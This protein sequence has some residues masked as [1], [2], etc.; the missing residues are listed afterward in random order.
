MSKQSHLLDD[1]KQ[2]SLSLFGVSYKRLAVLIFGVLAFGVYVGFLLFGENSL[3][4]YLKIEEQIRQNE[5]LV[6]LLKEEN[7]KL[8]KEFFELKEVQPK[9]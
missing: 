2:T 5:K 9:E 4:R 7:A 1:I 6:L 3:N 8:Q